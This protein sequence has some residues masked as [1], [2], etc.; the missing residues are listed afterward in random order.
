MLQ[1]AEFAVYEKDPNH[2][3][4][5]IPAKSEGAERL[6]KLL[7]RPNHQDSFGKTMYR[8]NQQLGLTGM[9]LTWMVPSMRPHVHPDQERY[10]N[11]GEPMELYCIPTAIAIPQ[12]A[13]NPDFPDGYYRIQPVYPYGPFSSYPTPVSAIGAPVAAQWML[14]FMYPH[15]LLRY[16]GYSPLTGLKYHMDELEMIDKSRHYK[17]RGSI[18]PSAILNLTDMEGSQ[19]LPESEIERMHA[20]WEAQYQG[21]EN[22]GKL[23]IGAPGGKLEEWGSRPVDMDY[24]VGWSQL[25]DFILGGGFGITKPAAGMVEDSS[26]ST[27]FATIK[28]LYVL[29]LQPEADD[30]AGELTHHLAPFFGDNLIIEIRCKRIDDHDITFTKIDKGL[31]ANVLTKN[32]V[33]KMLELPTT[34]EPWGEEMAGAAEQQSGV[35]GET[36][37]KGPQEIQDAEGRKAEREASRQ[38]KTEKQELPEPPEVTKT[39]PKTGNLGRG[40]LGPRKNLGQFKRKSLYDKVREVIANGHDK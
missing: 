21:S 8:I 27:L 26:Y 18:N 15:P 3:E 10:R 24:S 11:G 33:L 36:P 4:G 31:Q 40:A 6:I 5:K 19:P 30:I 1:Q 39:R 35:P 20:E 9:A 29:T 7:E 28:Q 37:A 22:H 2:P 13:I 32:Q 25:L 16:D 38:A 12:P 17:M 34:Q 14:R 23:I